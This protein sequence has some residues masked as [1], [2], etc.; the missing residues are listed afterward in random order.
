MR[1][2]ILLLIT[3]LFLAAC[4]SNPARQTANLTSTLS[5]TAPAICPASPDVQEIL[6]R[7][8]RSFGSKEAVTR[9]LPRSFTGE[10]V[11]QGKRGSVELALDRQGRFSQSTV[12]DGMLS[13]SGIDTKGPWF[14]GYAGVPVRLRND[15]AVEV[16]F[17]AWMQDR[18]YLDSFDPKR[19]SV[20]CTVGA[21]G[22]QISVQYSLPKIGNPGLHFG[23]SDASLRSVTH[24]DIHDHKSVLNFR[25]WSDADLTGVRWPLTIHR[26]EASGKDSLVTLTKSVPGVECPSRASEDCLAPPRSKLAFTW[27]KETPVRVPATFFLN[28]VILQARVGGRAFW[29]LVDSGATL[30]VIDQGSPIATAFQPATV[31]NSIPEQRSPFALGEIREA[32]KLGEL[33][34]EHLP[35]AAIPMPSFDEFG[36]RRP[37]ML[38][39]YPIFLGTA[40]RID[41]ARQEV[42]L[43]KE[44]RSLHSESAIPIPLKF[45]GQTVVAEA[46]IDGV[47][48]W[49][50]LDSGYS[51]AL[52][53]F[54]D[55]AVAHRFPGSRPNYNIQQKG[56]FGDSQTDE[57]RMRPATFELGPIRLTEP[58]VAIESVRSQSDRIA[59]QVGYGLF[60]RCSAVVF[61][62]ENRNLWLE[63]PCDRELPE[64]LSGWVLDKK[65]SAAYPDRPWVVKFVIPGGSAD[66]AGVKIGDRILQLGDK[67]AILDIST[68][69]SITKQTPGTMVPAVIVRGYASKVLML[70]LI[71]LLS[72]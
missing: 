16:A 14:L 62:M 34:I 45:L 17:A 25:S 63:P 39:G 1:Y 32:V 18:D 72:H 2:K 70:R 37:E 6:T 67:P 26:K 48:G 15:E 3:V 64:E 19:D 10:S 24:L 33:V 57:K 71:R 51:G 44:A 28:E 65:E 66:L 7:H 59:G 9:A 60:A 68:F 56:E 47:S 49:F 38:I 52:D 40:V 55:W 30:N 5:E 35:V 61:D 50:V 31:E 58:L 12:A 23:L 21:D 8:A 4:A 69:E 20:T 11:T 53:L 29:G 54:R 36:E 13:A 42:L 46:K 41:F 22:P 27:P 43:S